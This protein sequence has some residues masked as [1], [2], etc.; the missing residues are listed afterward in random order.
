MNSQ[1]KW[2][3]VVF[4]LFFLASTQSWGQLPPSVADINSQETIR[5]QERE[6]LL[7]QQQEKAPDVMLER[8]SALG[9][10]IPLDE[11]PCFPI[12]DIVLIGEGVERFRWALN[13]A[14]VPGDPNVG[15]CLGTQGINLVMKRIQNAIV[16]KGYVTTRV[17]AAPQDLQS[18]RLELTIVPG[19]IRDIRFSENRDGRGT[20]INALPENPEGLL[21]LRDIEQA[22]ENL[23]RVPTA[24][25]DIQISPSSAEGAGPGDSD[26]LVSYRQNFPF[27]LSMSVDDG[28]SK[29]TGKLQGS[30][31]FSYDNWL[32]LNDLFYLSVNENLDKGDSGNRGT[33]GYTAHYSL[34]L[35]YWLLGVTGSKNRYFQRVSGINQSYV[36]S[37]TSHNAE[38]KLSRNL[39]R[40]GTRKTTG[41]VK[42]W[43]KESNN[44]IDDTE[45]EVQR[46]RTAGWELGISHR[47]YL[48]ET[49][50][51]L[52]LAYRRGTGALRSLHA[53]EEN[54]GE[55]TSRLG[56][57][58]ADALLNVPF[59]VLGQNLRYSGQWRGQWNETPLVPQDRFSIGGRYTVRGYSGESVL[60]ADRGWLIRN[61][62]STPL[63]GSGQELYLGLDYGEV[64]G[65]SSAF[66]VGHYL[67][68]AVL[69]FRGGWGAVSYDVFVGQPV[70]HPSDFKADHSVTGFSIYFQL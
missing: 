6:R 20:L 41:W 54:F 34:P 53:P 35:G 8:Q 37:G 31:T 68:G 66:L 52:S 13:D 2:F 40:D 24:D 10:R 58:T 9:E 19:K 25:A 51:D 22:L 49:V 29:A 57:V 39:Y 60:S 11:Q 14:S 3:R 28:G 30:T 38:V 69:G 62:L 15:R 42:G 33:S 18:G 48:A 56:L 61:D 27:R 5:Q 44:Y 59:R 17:L 1:Y 16:A 32:T 12:R 21:N 23:K 7:R 50:L 36:Y 4:P 63:G 47:E 26:L 65:P 55:G 70:K 46:R 64:G 67:A 43:L 45:V